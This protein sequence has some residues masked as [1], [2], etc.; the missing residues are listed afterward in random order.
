[1]LVHANLTELM[2][3]SLGWGGEL[4]ADRHLVMRRTISAGHAARLIVSYNL[5]DGY[6][7][8]GVLAGLDGLSGLSGQAG[9]VGFCD[10]CQVRGLRRIC[11]ICGIQG[12]RGLPFFGGQFQAPHI[13]ICFLLRSP[14][15]REG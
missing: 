7:V 9:F 4:G 12:L 6:G 3:D 8:L 15:E 14:L 11:G 13:F 1:M 5:R 2:N 10:V